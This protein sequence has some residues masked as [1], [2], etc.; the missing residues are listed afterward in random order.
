MST[1]PKLW[2]PFPLLKK[3]VINL[4]G[5]QLSNVLLVSHPPALLYTLPSPLIKTPT[6]G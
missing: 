5:I 1:F 6:M 3:Y 2:V 4:E